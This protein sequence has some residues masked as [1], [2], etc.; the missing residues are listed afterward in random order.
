MGGE[1]S[2]MGQ[3]LELLR[4]VPSGYVTDTFVRLDLR[5]WIRGLRV[6]RSLEEKHVAGPAVTVEYAPIRGRRT[7]KW[8]LYEI[9]RGVAP[10]SIVVLAGTSPRGVTV[11]AN[12][13]TAASVAGVQ[14]LMLDGCLRDLQDIRNLGL[15]VFY[16]K[17]TITRDPTYEIVA[18]NQ[19]VT[20]AGARVHADD[21]VVADEDGGA[22]IPPQYLESVIENVRDVARLEE[23]QAE[24]IRG[25]GALE[26]LKKVLIAKKAPPSE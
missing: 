6:T 1:V 23:E 22:V 17:V 4:E 25:E 18:L 19:P 3:S 14:A 12:V 15:P 2:A 5:G 21:I 20:F 8:N 9:L 16:R 26:R 24:L 10:G 13:S 7:S 11:G